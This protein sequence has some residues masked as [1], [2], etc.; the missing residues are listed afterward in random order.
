[1]RNSQ[2][3]SA[4]PV[5]AVLSKVASQLNLEQDNCK[6]ILKGIT[7]SI[8]PGEILDLMPLREEQF[9]HRIGLTRD[10]VLFPQLTV[11]ET[12]VF[13]AFLRLPGNMSQQQKYARLEPKEKEE[14]HRLEKA[15]EYLLAI[16]FK[17]EWTLAI[18]DT[19]E[20]N[21]QRKA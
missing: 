19:V 1:M 12:L 15:P 11:D 2:A 7:G 5:K 6:K 14:S 4:N 18:C 13:A 16:Q 3:S 17:K 10:D 9:V 8:G 21:I 20:E